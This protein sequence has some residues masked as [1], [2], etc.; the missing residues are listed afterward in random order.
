MKSLRGPLRKRRRPKD[1]SAL[2][3]RLRKR[4]R[5]SRKARRIRN[6]ED[7]NG[8]LGRM[9]LR[10]FNSKPKALTRLTCYRF[11]R[12]ANAVGTKANNFRKGR[13]ISWPGTV[14]TGNS[15]VLPKAN[16]L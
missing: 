5:Q 12:G 2:L 10:R 7:W 9:S 3:L 14:S 4:R 1:Q 8:K 11:T 16:R 6:A 13:K 15:T